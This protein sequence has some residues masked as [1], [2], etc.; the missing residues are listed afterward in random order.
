M[1][2]LR[3]VWKRCLALLCS[4]D[5]RLP[6]SRTAGGRLHPISSQVIPCGY[7]D[8]IVARGG[9]WTQEAQKTRRTVVRLAFVVSGG[10]LSF[11]ALRTWSLRVAAGAAALHSLA[12]WMFASLHLPLAALTVAVS[13][14][15]AF[16]ALSKARPGR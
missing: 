3:C 11:R 15:K 13:Q 9:R 8:C 1:V 6:A 2:A 12:H 10:Y 16:H 4:L 7:L 5:V 14:A